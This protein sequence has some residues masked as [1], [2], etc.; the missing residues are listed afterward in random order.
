[1]DNGRSWMLN[2]NAICAAR[3]CI[4]IT[5][6]ELGISLKLT[7]PQFVE[8]LG[9]YADLT[10][11]QELREAVVELMAYYHQRNTPQA[12]KTLEKKRHTSDIMIDGESSIKKYI[13][14]AGHPDY[15]PQHQVYQTAVGDG[16]QAGHQEMTMYGGKQYPTYN[17]E[18][19]KFK[20]LYRGQPHYA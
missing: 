1:M 4:Q 8:M 20:G 17:R 11:S 19:K 16:I 3:K 18:G 7:H 10:D 2:P 9:E 5:Q 14:E 12:G 6:M 15:T 13:R